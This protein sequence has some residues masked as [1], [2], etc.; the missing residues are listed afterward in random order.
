MIPEIQTVRASQDSQRRRGDYYPIPSSA[1]D[2]RCPS[3][4]GT[5]ILEAWWIVLERTGHFTSNHDGG[6]SPG[7]TSA[8]STSLS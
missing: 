8:P 4:R 6:Y 1:V 5:L 3:I 7:E 2:V